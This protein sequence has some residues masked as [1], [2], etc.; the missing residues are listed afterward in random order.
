MEAIIFE[1]IRAII[2]FF[3][4]ITL[5]K[6]YLFL[7]VSPFYVLRERQRY[8]KQSLRRKAEGL[9]KYAPKI[10]VVIPAWNEGKGVIKTIDSVLYNGYENVEVIV[11][12]DGSTDNSNELIKKYV[13][14]LAKNDPKSIK[15]LHYIYKENGGKGKALNTGVEKAKG[16]IILTVDADS[17]LIE[18]SLQNLTKYF[19]DDEITACSILKIRRKTLKCRCVPNT[20]A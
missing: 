8:I 13:A 7:L 6:N 2:M 4:I 12:N 5:F 9:P 20:T 11:I 14:S 3:V 15:R 17:V 1:A 10:S 18:G 16:E 19:M